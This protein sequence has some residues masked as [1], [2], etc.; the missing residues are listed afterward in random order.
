ME[1]LQSYASHLV[2]YYKPRGV[3]RG[4]CEYETYHLHQLYPTFRGC[5]VLLRNN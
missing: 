2:Q 3:G 1:P 5:N 4:E